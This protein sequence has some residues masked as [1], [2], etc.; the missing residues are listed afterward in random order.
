MTI[1]DKTM[2]L[3][4]SHRGVSDPPYLGRF[5]HELAKILLSMVWLGLRAPLQ[6]QEILVVHP[7]P[8]EL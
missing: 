5:G 8:T 7:R 3:I 1:F 6:S 2:N 4:L